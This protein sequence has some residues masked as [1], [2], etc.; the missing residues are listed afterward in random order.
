MDKSRQR[1]KKTRNYKRRR[2]KQEDGEETE[3][4]KREEKETKTRRRIQKQKKRLKEKTGRRNKR[5]GEE[6]KKNMRRKKKQRKKNEQKQKRCKFIFSTAEHRHSMNTPTH[7]DLLR[8]GIGSL[9]DLVLSLFGET[10]AG[11]TQ[12][13]TVARLH[14]HASLDHRLPFLHHGPENRERW[15]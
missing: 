14:V 1:K 2:K 3:K 4:K 13:V 5:G 15:K 6:K 7:L 9:L 12:R 11:E 8:L 10:N